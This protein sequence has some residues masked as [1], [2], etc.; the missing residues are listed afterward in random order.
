MSITVRRLSAEEIKT[1]IRSLARLRIEVFK[2]FPYIYDGSDEYE[3]KYLQKYLDSSRAALIAAFDEKNVIGVASCLPL[4]DEDSS[5]QKPFVEKG[6]DLK[7]VFYFGESVLQ[8]K[9]RGRGIGK[10]FFQEREKWA[11]SFGQYEITT[12]CAVKRPAEHPLKHLDFRPLDEFWK[13]QGYEK[14]PELHTEFSWQDI[15]EKSETFKKMIFWLK[16]WS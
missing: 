5:V 15:G 16:R 1:E 11:R 3:V 7:K 13:A 8:K 14:H 4:V 9:Y 6:F 2:D 12:F 10:T